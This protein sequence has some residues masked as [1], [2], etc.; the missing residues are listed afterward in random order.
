MQSFGY[1]GSL[2]FLDGCRPTGLRSREPISRGCLLLSVV[3]FDPSS[4]R[5]D[6]TEQKN[7][8]RVPSKK[9]LNFI[10]S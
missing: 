4:F 8:R 7:I 6:P 1:L 9:Y 2:L 5:S 3:N 10:A